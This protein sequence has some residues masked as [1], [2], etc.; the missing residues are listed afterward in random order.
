MKR[1][2]PL[3]ILILLCQI[4]SSQKENNY[5]ELV[6]I[7]SQLNSMF[8]VLYNEEVTGLHMDLYHSIDTLFYYALHLPGAGNYEWKKLDNI[9]K[10]VSDDGKFKI[11]SWLYMEN[12]DHYH[13]TCYFLIRDRRDEFEVFKLKPSDDEGRKTEIFSQK[14]DNWHGKIYYEIHTTEYRRKDYYTIMGADFNDINSS[15]KTIE[16]VTI[17]RGKP[18]FR[19]DQFFDD[20]KVKDRMVF[21]YSSELAVTVRYNKQLDMIVFD[22]LAPLHPIYAGNYQFYGPDGSYDGLKFIDG[23]WVRE[24]DVDAR[25]SR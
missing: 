14:P 24:A 8:Q 10:L 21:E 1:F 11:F 6:K 25:N 18:V 15:I 13:Y 5:L 9:G 23:M 20:G 3:Y 22:H 2:I 16:V 4:G 17:Q 7:E 12:R 19:G